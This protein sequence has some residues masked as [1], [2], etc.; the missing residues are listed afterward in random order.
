MGS[1]FSIDTTTVR[2]SVE[3]FDDAARF[4]RFG[5]N[6]GQLANAGMPLADELQIRLHNRSTTTVKIGMVRVR[7][8]SRVLPV[9]TFGPVE[10]R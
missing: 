8:A 7:R 1:V 10:Q 6:V 9:V 4:R 5:V 3:R 2:Y